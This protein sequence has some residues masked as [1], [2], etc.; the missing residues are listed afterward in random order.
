MILLHRIGDKKLS[1]NF[2]TRQEV[3]NST[4]ILSFDGIYESVIENDDIL[5]GREV[6]LF[7]MGDYVG[8]D[9]T[10]DSGE[11]YSR[12]LDWNE[13][14]ELCYDYDCKLGWHTWSHRDLRKLSDEELQKEVTAPIPMDWFAYPYGEFDERVIRAVAKAGFKDAW[15]VNQGDDGPFQR[16]RFYL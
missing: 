11:P 6:F 5:E 10:F 7:V 12:Y 3:K 14:M 2:N 15:S 4:G 9:N 1:G 16:K 8:V 13:I